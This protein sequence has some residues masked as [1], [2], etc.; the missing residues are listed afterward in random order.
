[1]HRYIKNN[2]GCISLKVIENECEISIR[3][4]NLNL[5]VQKMVDFIDKDKNDAENKKIRSIDDVQRGIKYFREFR[6]FNKGIYFISTRHQNEFISLLNQIDEVY[7]VAYINALN[8]DN[9]L[10]FEVRNS[11]DFLYKHKFSFPTDSLVTI[12]SRDQVQVIYHGH[13]I[14]THEEFQKGDYEVLSD[15][16]GESID[17]LFICDLLETDKNKDIKKF[18]QFMSYVNSKFFNSIT[19]NILNFRF[20]RNVSMESSFKTTFFKILE[21]VKKNLWDLSF[22]MANYIYSLKGD[23]ND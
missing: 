7:H 8:K 5:W 6:M 13:I 4:K 20:P 19:I 2:K 21:K 10:C 11:D 14:H 18:N 12:Y 1:M 15:V 17:N 16:S 3:D 23:R 22:H 9:L